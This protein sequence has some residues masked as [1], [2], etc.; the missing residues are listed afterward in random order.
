MYNFFFLYLII[1]LK[2]RGG[3]IKVIQNKVVFFIPFQSSFPS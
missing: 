1:N 2:K 3:F